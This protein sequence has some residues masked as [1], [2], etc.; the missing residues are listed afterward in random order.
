VDC[1]LR[2]PSGIA[3]VMGVLSKHVNPRDV[4]DDQ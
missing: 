3:E 2:V 1:K 4:I